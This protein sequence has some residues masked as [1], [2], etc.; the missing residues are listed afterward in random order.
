VT[1][2]GQLRLVT[3]AILT[4]GLRSSAADRVYEI[5]EEFLELRVT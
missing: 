1:S 5:A 3:T 2:G 4:G